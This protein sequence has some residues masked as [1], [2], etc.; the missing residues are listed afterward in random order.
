MRL[1]ISNFKSLVGVVF[2]V[3]VLS[4][5]G[6]IGYRIVTVQI[7]YPIPGNKTEAWF[8]NVAR[9]RELLYDAKKGTEKKTIFVIGGSNSLFSTA[10]GVLAD[11]TGYNVRNY[12]LHAGLHIDILF[13]QIRTKVK[14]GDIVLAPLEWETR[15]RTSI[16]QFDYENYLHHFSKSVD[17][18]PRV[19]YEVFSSVPLRRWVDGIKSYLFLPYSAESYWQFYTPES[20]QYTWD[21]REKNENYT[22]RALNQYGDINIELPMTA[23]TWKDKSIFQVPEK[24]DPKWAE[25]LGRWQAY[26]DKQG[27][28]LFVTSPILLEGNGPEIASVDT[29]RRIATIRDQ[30][31]ATGTPLNCDPIQA[32]FSTIY[33]FDTSY[34]ANAEGARQR[35]QELGACLLDFI[36]GKDVQT[37]PIDPEQAAAGVARRL[38]EQ[39]RDFGSGSMPFQVRLREITQINH[40]VRQYHA[41]YGKYPRSTKPQG[42]GL[43]EKG[44]TSA[45]QDPG[46][47][48]WSDENSYKLIAKVP[49]LECAVV[50]A[51]WPQMIDPVGLENN[52]PTLCTGFGY[53]TEDQK[54][55]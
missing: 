12:S 31:A 13:S 49:K 3:A 28:K 45:I 21:H 29:W 27:V 50:G 53:W 15:S 34:H 9:M 1:S 47:V 42:W 43:P 48:Y 24:M 35:T 55:R 37:K 14:A 22:H 6:W 5:L 2:A 19:L 17:L 11:K 33:R 40:D 25:E 39:R 46:M 32:T 7:G 44:A 4:A 20:L 51:N 36:G 30:M 52:D 16:N 8:G 38:A 26:F 18:S 54:L 41:K 23:A 10:S